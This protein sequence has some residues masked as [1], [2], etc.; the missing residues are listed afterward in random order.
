VPEP[1]ANSPQQPTSA[2]EK[3]ETKFWVCSETHLMFATRNTVIGYAISEAVLREAHLKHY[4]QC[5]ISSRRFQLLGAGLS[6]AV[7]HVETL[8][9]ILWVINSD[10]CSEPLPI[11]ELSVAVQ[12]HDL[13]LVIRCTINSSL[14]WEPLLIRLFYSSLNQNNCWY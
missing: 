11:C 8:L 13:P 1:T 2:L 10:L 9:I 12:K 3:I 7:L 5:F 4:Q 14:L 6:K